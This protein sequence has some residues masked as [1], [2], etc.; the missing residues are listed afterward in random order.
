VDRAGKAGTASRL[1][2]LVGL[3]AAEARVEA[4]GPGAADV[5]IV[6]GTDFRGLR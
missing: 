5:T 1:A 4:G 6:L 2:A 3:G